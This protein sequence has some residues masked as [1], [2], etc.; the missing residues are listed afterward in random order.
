MI[1]ACK[2]QNFHFLVLLFLC[3]IMSIVNAIYM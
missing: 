1:D 3:G 2:F